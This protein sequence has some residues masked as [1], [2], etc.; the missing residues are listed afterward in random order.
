[1]AAVIRDVDEVLGTTRAVRRRLDFD[2]PVPNEVIE[3]CL[4]LAQ[5][6]TLG[7]NNE[8]WRFVI[9]TEAAQKERIAEV[10]RDVWD[11]TVE[12]PL[13]TRHP[14]TVRRLDP[15]V[16]GSEYEQRRQERVLASVK[17]LVDRLEQVPGL[18]IA[19]SVS[20]APKQPVG[21]RASGYYGSII[22]AVWSFQL[23]LRS[24]GLGSVMA[25]ALVYHAER[26]RE[27][28]ELPERFTPIT[29]V[30]FGYTKGLDFQRVHRRPL[31]EIM[32]YDR[33][34]EDE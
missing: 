32:R 10:Y 22:P 12:E 26:V 9:V 23:A 7:S 29:M 30:P 15:S 5:Q 1:V 19:C 13:R 33:W 2:R 24:R 8:D 21:D 11:N 3:E 28:L 18:A 17:Y 20:P 31:S 6:A 4:L 25:T 16:R 14:D 34:G 27:V